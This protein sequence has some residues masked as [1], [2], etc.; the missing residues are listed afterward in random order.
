MDIKTLEQALKL[1]NDL[2]ARLTQ[3][4]VA[5]RTGKVPAIKVTLKEKEELV[6]RAQ[7]EVETAIKE[8][9]AAVSR[10]NERVAQRKANVVKLQKELDDLKEQLV[11]RN[12]PP[13]DKP[14]NLKKEVRRKKYFWFTAIKTLMRN[15]DL[16]AS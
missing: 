12:D 8:R 16:C 11:E 9:D 13:K 5:Q 2:T 14:G 3:S 15:S 4:M 1:Q 7:A 10:W 6:T